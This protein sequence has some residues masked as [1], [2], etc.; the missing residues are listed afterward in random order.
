MTA[1]F[2]HPGCSIWEIA[3]IRCLVCIGLVF[4]LAASANAQDWAKARLEKSSRHGEWVKLK[5]DKREIQAFV[6]YPEIKEKAT[7]VIVIHEIFGLT[8]WVR[9][10]CDQLGEAGYI[11]IAPDLLSGTGPKGGGTDSFGGGDAVRKAILSLPA[12]QITGDLNAANDYVAKL[13]ACN[14]KVVVSGFCFGGSQTFRYATNSKTVK[15]AFVFYG[16]GPESEADIKRIESPVSGFYGGNDA[17]VNMTIP[18]SKDLMKDAAKA[19]DPVTYEGAGHG[20]MRAGEEPN[21]TEANK[22]AKDEAWK[23]WK[24]LLKKV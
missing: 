17:R 15:A 7:A 23:R 16:T 3:V 11:A 6:V 18:K 10:V 22:K 13:P 8:D 1:H 2:S 12:D 24:E 14:G 21:A 20:F 19:Y 9:L 5:N 4:F